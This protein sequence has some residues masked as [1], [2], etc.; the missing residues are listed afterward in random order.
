ML[1]PGH[2]YL[3]PGNPTN[4]GDPVDWDDEIA[5]EHDLAYDKANTQ[6]DITKA[7]DTAIKEFFSDF[8]QT[9]NFHSLVGGIGL[10]LKRGAEA[11]FGPIYPNP[12]MSKRH[13]TEET[14]DSTNGEGVTGINPSAGSS[15]PGGT[16]AD[17]MATIIKNPH[18]ETV[19]MCF[20]KTFQMYT[21]GFQFKQIG[22]TEFF[23]GITNPFENN[24]KIFLT[25]LA[26][27]DPG[28]LWM[29]MTPSEFKQL[30]LFSYATQCGIKVTPLGY[31]LPFQTNE[32]SAGYA[33]SQTLVQC[34]YTTGLNNIMNITLTNYEINESDPTNIS[35]TTSTEPDYIA[36]MY[37]D[38]NNT[39]AIT[40]AP[41]HFNQYTG[42]LQN[43]G[44]NEVINNSPMLTNY[45]EIRNVNDCKGMPVINYSHQFKNGILKWPQ[46]SS[47]RDILSDT[48]VL[49]NNYGILPEGFNQINPSYYS[50]QTNTTNT[51]GIVTDDSRVRFENSSTNWTEA[52]LYNFTVEKAYWLQKQFGQHQTPDYTP[53]VH[54]GCLPVPSNFALSPTETYA[55]SV[56]Q[57]QIETM[58]CVDVNLNSLDS[59]IQIPYNKGWDPISHNLP[60]IPRNNGRCLLVQNRRAIGVAQQPTT[61]VKKINMM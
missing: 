41:T 52:Q 55:A 39:G 33:N 57:W 26:C 15:L 4:N 29:Y 48:T 43:R 12:D 30:P 6:Q 32:A 44:N 58:I 46:E 7:D 53:M 36:L 54:F 21:G 10:G 5:R 28:S 37:G 25:P 1:Y 3:G 19:K 47:T 2:K 60:N 50:S 9:N 22:T 42:I 56:I 51:E 34:A 24:A 8:H 14:P 11:I 27:L 49:V 17:V 45:M 61:N 16:G 31:R 20:N 38:A 18:I 13:K 35:K 40:G 59:F 23:T